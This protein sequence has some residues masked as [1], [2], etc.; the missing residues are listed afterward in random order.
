MSLTEK[1]RIAVSTARRALADEKAG[2]H[3]GNDAPALAYWVGRYRR[4]LE[5]ISEEFPEDES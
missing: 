5:I 3:S 4:A 2:E 1:Q